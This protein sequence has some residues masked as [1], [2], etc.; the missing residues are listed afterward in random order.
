MRVWEQNRP[1]LK[2]AWMLRHM[3]KLA[4]IVRV[5]AGRKHTYT[6]WCIPPRLLLKSWPTP[7]AEGNWNVYN[8]HSR[9]V[10]YRHCCETPLERHHCTIRAGFLRTSSAEQRSFFK[11][12]YWQG[13]RLGTARV[14]VVFLQPF[15]FEQNKL[16]VFAS[17]GWKTLISAIL[18]QKLIVALRWFWGAGYG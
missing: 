18:R 4:D 3:N 6:E 10:L 14:V 12:F 13:G 11:A 2:L 5:I 15:L 9:C 16:K 8:W 17:T 1:P 7:I